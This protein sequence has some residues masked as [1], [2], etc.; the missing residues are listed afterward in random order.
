MESAI[1]FC[2]LKVSVNECDVLMK[3]IKHEKGK[4]EDDPARTSLKE[5]SAATD[6]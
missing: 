5:Q 1:D 6:E 3:H 4:I 2:V